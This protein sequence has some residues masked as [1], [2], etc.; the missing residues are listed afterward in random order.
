MICVHGPLIGNACIRSGKRD[1]LLYTGDPKADRQAERAVSD[2]R[3][4]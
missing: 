3:P 4:V 2:L 1:E